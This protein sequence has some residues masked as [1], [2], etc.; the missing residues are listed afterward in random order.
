MSAEH[1]PGP[2]KAVGSIPEEG[3]DCFWISGTKVGSDGKPFD[4]DIATVNGSQRSETCQANAHLIAAAPDMLKA[5]R[6]AVMALAAA[7]EKWPQH[8]DDEYEIVSAAIAKA[9]GAAA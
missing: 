3:C 5:L 9:T 8:F 2:W 6:R 7:S 4:W 1:A